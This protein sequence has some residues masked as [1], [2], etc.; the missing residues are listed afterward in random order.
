MSLTKGPGTG[1]T[2]RSTGVDCFRPHPG[3][4]QSCAVCTT[5]VGLV[6]AWAMG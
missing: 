3:A 1:R 2:P 5:V 6:R 4:E